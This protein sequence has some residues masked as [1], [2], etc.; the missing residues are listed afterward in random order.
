MK[1]L[2][3]FTVAALFSAI[4]VEAATRNAA[5]CSRTDVGNAV[6]SAA[7]GDTI[8]IPA[9]TCTWT[10]SLA[11]TNKILT[12]QGAGPNSTVIVDGVSKATYPNIPEVLVWQTKP[13]GISRITGIGFEGGSIVDPMGVSI[14]KI[15]GNS[16]QFRFDHSRV[17]TTESSAIIIRGNVLGVIDHVAFEL[18]NWKFGVMLHLE[19]WNNTGDFG[20]ASWADDSYIGTDK[21]VF[22]ED[23]SFTGTGNQVA[24][25]GWSGSRVVFRYNQLR[26][27]AWENHGLETAGRWRSMRT[28]EIYNNTFTWDSMVWA[29]MIGVRGGTGVIFNNTGTTTGSAYTN[30]LA[31]LNTLRSSDFSRPYAPWGHCDGSNVWDGNQNSAGWP[32]MDQPGRGKGGMMSSFDPS[33]VGY[34]NQVNDPV[35][36]WNN[37]LNGQVSK[38]RSNAPNSVQEGRDFFSNPKPGYTPYT[39]PHPLTTGSTG[40]GGSSTPTAPSNLR[41]LSSE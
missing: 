29:S 7:D 4:N 17:K 39:Y 31:D 35:Y 23:C 5:S 25:D 28:Y 36:G 1:V 2:A 15:V 12:L 13:G 18:N 38:I 14:L 30:V 9:G 16:H 34:P 27:A 40:S 26:N 6:N 10:T 21:A 32:C 41:I 8:V 19:S 3:C 20:D 24:I 37:T 11:I 22:I 33:P